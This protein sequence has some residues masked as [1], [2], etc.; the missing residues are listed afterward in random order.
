M[1][2]ETVFYTTMQSPIGVLHLFASDDNLL[3]IG[4]KKDEV[5]SEA[6]I[7]KKTNAVLKN[8]IAQL[9]EYFNGERKQFD[10]PL[11]FDG[12]D[13]QVKAWKALCD[14]PYGKTISYGEQAEKVGVKK[15]FRAIGSANGRNQ[16][17]IV[18]PCHRV[19]ASDGTLGG[20]AGGLKI[21][22]RLLQLER[23]LAT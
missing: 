16:L 1:K 23:G 4:F 9:T 11:K 20:Y 5:K 2:A 21:K 7:Q 18:V 15:A 6:T 17:P 14:I 10:L 19:V 13:F 22:M 3:S 8:A 12:T